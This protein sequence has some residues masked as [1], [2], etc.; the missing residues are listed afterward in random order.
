MATFDKLLNITKNNLSTNHIESTRVYWKYVKGERHLLYIPL[1]LCVS[2][3]E[4]DE[5]Q[6]AQLK[7]LNQKVVDGEEL[8]MEQKQLRS[9][10]SIQQAL[11]AA[12]P[13]LGNYLQTN[14]NLIEAPYIYLQFLI[15]IP[16]IICSAR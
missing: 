2:F 1:A 5:I 15:S 7:T 8:T 6:R 11:V 14:L 10:L 3:L 9:E 16:T 12:A 4:M 13:A